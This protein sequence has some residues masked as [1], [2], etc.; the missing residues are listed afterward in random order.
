MSSL[1]ETKG[2]SIF[3][4]K[5]PRPRLIVPGPQ[6]EERAVSLLPFPDEAVAGRHAA[7]TLKL[8]R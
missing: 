1:A 5:P 7:F 3:T 8:V 4:D 2:P 6:E